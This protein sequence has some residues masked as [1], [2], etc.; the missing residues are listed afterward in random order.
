MC[1]DVICI[2]INLFVYADL[3]QSGPKGELSSF[4][5]VSLEPDMVV[6]EA[7]KE[8][9]TSPDML[10]SLEMAP[11]HQLHLQSDLEQ[12]V[13]PN[14]LPE[15]AFYVQQPHFNVSGCIIILLYML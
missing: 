1:C 15:V 3:L 4:D 6:K 2:S 11:S 8:S 5:R 9:A 10:Q 14:I 7:L 13:T 12:P